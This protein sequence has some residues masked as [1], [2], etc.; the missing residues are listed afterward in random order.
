MDWD[1]YGRLSAGLAE[2]MDCN[3]KGNTE[4]EFKS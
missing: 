1:T 2:F 3:K 4:N